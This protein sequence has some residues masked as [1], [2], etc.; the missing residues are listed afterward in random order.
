[1]PWISNLFKGNGLWIPIVEE[2]AEE[3]VGQLGQNFVNYFTGKDKELEPGKDLLKSFIQGA[4][5]GSQFSMS[6]GG[7]MVVDQHMQTFER[8]VQYYSLLYTIIIS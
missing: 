3:F 7:L 5:G 4:A 2:G 8:K 1:M 6:E